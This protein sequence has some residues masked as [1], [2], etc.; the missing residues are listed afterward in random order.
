MNLVPAPCVTEEDCF[1]EGCPLPPLEVVPRTAFVAE[2][3]EV[4]A[5]LDG[6]LGDELSEPL[7][8]TLD[9]VPGLERERRICALEHSGDVRFQL[10]RPGGGGKKLLGAQL[11]ALIH[12]RDIVCRQLPEMPRD[13]VTT[14]LF[15]PDHR[16]IVTLRGGVVTGGVTYRPFVHG[17]PDGGFAEIA[18]FVVSTDSHVQGLGTRQMNRL[19]A[20]LVADG[21]FHILTCAD[22]AALGFFQNHGFSDAI[23]LPDARWFGRIKDYERGVLM[24]ATLHAQMPY[25]ALPRAVL[26]SREA[27]MGEWLAGG[28]L[29]LV[30]APTGGESGG[31]ESGGEGGGDDTEDIVGHLLLGSLADA[32][33]RLVSPAYATGLGGGLVGVRLLPAEG[34]AGEAGEAGASGAWGRAR[35]VEAASELSKLLLKK[36]RARTAGTDAFMPILCRAQCG[37]YADLGTEALAECHRH[38]L[39]VY[40]LT[41]GELHRCFSRLR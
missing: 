3:M 28:G 13:Y 22:N 20:Q 26:E 33:A 6:A 17:E 7:G 19:K 27:A 35:G 2:P 23:T 9:S 18:F 15:R 11:L 39:A 25:T 34:E 24:Q 36:V 10:I 40:V 30:E 1:D 41:Q 16:S 38:G 5:T 12:L 21:C 4:E 14:L 8:D 31:G 37:Y 29:E 32:S